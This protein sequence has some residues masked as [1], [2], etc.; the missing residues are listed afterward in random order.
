M[1]SISNPMPANAAIDPTMDIVFVWQNWLVALLEA[2]LYWEKPWAI[3]THV[4][5]RVD[6]TEDLSAEAS[7]VKKVQHLDTVRSCRR[8]ESFRFPDK[9]PAEIEE[10]RKLVGVVC[11][12]KY[13]YDFAFYLRWALNVFIIPVIVWLAA[14]VL[15]GWWH[16][17]LIVFFLYVP[18]NY[19]L[20]RWSRTTWACSEISSKIYGAFGKRFV[21]GRRFD[22]SSPHIMWMMV[23]FAEWDNYERFRKGKPVG[24]GEFGIAEFK[25]P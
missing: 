22:R 17:L 7:G 21:L 8:V 6:G 12:K 19:W 20:K 9:S 3:P 25:V 14:A 15:S 4:Q 11:K 16:V 1:S 13:A 5:I 23:S 10:Y 18:L 2:M 24:A